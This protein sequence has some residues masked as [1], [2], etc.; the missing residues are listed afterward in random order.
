MTKN[1]KFKITR[2]TNDKNRPVTMINPEEL[3]KFRALRLRE[4][5][6]RVNE[7]ISP[8]AQATPSV[9]HSPFFP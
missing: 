7:I 9:Y 2:V 6:K 4:L 3:Q 8:Q 1:Y 5:R